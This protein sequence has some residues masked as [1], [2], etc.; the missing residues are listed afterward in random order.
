MLS[1]ALADSQYLYDENG[2]RI[3]KKQLGGD[4]LYHF[5]LL[6]QL[7]KAEY[8]SYREEL[9]YDKTGNRTR[10]VADGVE[11]L[12]RYDMGNRLVSLTRGGVT[13]PFQYDNAGNLLKDDHAVLV[14]MHI[15]NLTNYSN[16]VVAIANM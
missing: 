13:T 3:Q 2:N 1:V 7:V 15:K 8:P 10:R 14:H 9:F 5:E 11:E 6:N 16:H 12:Y 4:T